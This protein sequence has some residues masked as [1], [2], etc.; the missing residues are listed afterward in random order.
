MIRIQPELLQSVDGAGLKGFMPLANQLRRA[1]RPVIERGKPP[2]VVVPTASRQK[3]RDGLASTMPGV[4]VLAE[5]EISDETFVEVFA[6]IGNTSPQDAAAGDRS[7]A[8]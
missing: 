1:A 7:R 5:E 2:V 6:T 3:V 4:T 8:A